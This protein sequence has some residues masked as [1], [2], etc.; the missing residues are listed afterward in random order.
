MP[1]KDRINALLVNKNLTY[2][3]LAKAVGVTR[4]GVQSWS[5]GR[6]EPTGKNLYKLAQY[7]GVTAEWLKT[8]EHPTAAVVSSAI[9]L[10][11]EDGEAPLDENEYVYIPEYSLRFSAGPGAEAPSWEEM[12]DAPLAVYKRSF[13]Q[14][15]HVNPKRCRRATVS[16]DSME[17]VLWDKDKILFEEVPEGSLR[18]KDGAVYALS[19][20][21]DMRVK[22]LYLKAN[23]DIVVHSDNPKYEDEV[24]T[25]EDRNRVRIYGRVLDKCGSGGL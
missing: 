9:A 1:F 25:G 15:N 24:I 12:Q 16:G 4:Q 23:G 21:G 22:R 10:E 20:G 6:T 8:G 17:P 2:T 19:Y 18:I 14:K 11:P 3:D 7:F 13:F 5:S